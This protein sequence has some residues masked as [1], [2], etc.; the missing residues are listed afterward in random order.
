MKIR[1]SELKNF[2]EQDRR[3]TFT[4]TVLLRSKTVK[5][6]KNN[7]EFLVLEFVDNSGS[8]TA[9]CFDGA[10]TYA[11]LQDAPVG[12]AF[13]ICASVDFFNGRPSPKIES[14]RKLSDEETAAEMPF[15]V[16]VSKYDPAAMKAELL[17]YAGKISNEALRCTDCLSIP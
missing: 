14:A 12:T 15:L 3:K 5:T 8:M 9:M 17:D 11:V 16:A 13:E 6:A 10:P 1:L 7:T 4:A 2:G